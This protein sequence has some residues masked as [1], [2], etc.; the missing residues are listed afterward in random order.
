MDEQ[1]TTKSDS[2]TSIELERLVTRD[3]LAA[4]HKGMKV[5]AE[6]LLG[7]ITRGKRPDKLDRYLLGEMLNH[8]ELVGK[9]YYAGDVTGVDEFLQLYCLAETRPINNKPASKN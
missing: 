7:R 6:G 2:G 9:R 4:D 5:S 3:L 8:L 1:N